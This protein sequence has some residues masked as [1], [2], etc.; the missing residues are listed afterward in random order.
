MK[1][2]CLQS[3]TSRWL[4]KRHLEKRLKSIIIE[5]SRAKAED[6]ITVFDPVRPTPAF[7]RE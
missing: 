1:A 3:G 4:P 2:M 6:V 7:I 5:F